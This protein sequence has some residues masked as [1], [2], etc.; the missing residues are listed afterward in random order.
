MSITCVASSR[1]A[2]LSENTMLLAHGLL[3][4]ISRDWHTSGFMFLWQFKGVRNFIAITN[5]S[6]IIERLTVWFVIVL[7]Q[8]VKECM[9]LFSIKTLLTESVF[10]KVRKWSESH[11]SNWMWND[12]VFLLHLNPCIKFILHSLTFWKCSSNSIHFICVNIFTSLGLAIMFHI[13]P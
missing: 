2:N 11:V 5:H 1:N 4:F 7:C 3:T 9:V 6:P 8:P 10:E 12:V 13:S